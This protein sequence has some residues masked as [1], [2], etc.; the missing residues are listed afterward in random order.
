LAG[1]DWKGQLVRASNKLQLLNENFGEGPRGD[2][3]RAMRNKS[4][5]FL[6]PLINYL[7]FK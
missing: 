3:I 4:L 2:R 7:V 6:S 1:I 5:V